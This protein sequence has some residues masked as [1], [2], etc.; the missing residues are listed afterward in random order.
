MP[1]KCKEL[2]RVHPERS[3]EPTGGLDPTSHIPSSETPTTDDTGAR[4]HKAHFKQRN[5]QNRTKA[6][7]VSSPKWNKNR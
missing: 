3:P 4:G 5:L 2:Y 1:T 6:V 7:K